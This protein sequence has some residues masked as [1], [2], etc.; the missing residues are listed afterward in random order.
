MKKL[1]PNALSFLRIALAFL[2]IP[3]ILKNDFVFACVLFGTAALSDFFDGYFAR[4]LHASSEFGAALDPLADKIL[5]TISYVLLANAKLIPL[6]AVAIVIGRDVLILLAVVACK[7]SNVALKMRPLMSSKINTA[8][9]ALFVSLVLTCNALSANVSCLVELFAA[10]VA[11]ST[12][13]SGAEYARKYYWIK[14]KL[15]K[16]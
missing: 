11:V 7:I 2:L 8:I 1:I 14:D 5:V 3:A 6:Y 13:F 10:V 9:Q 4:K 16:R 15:F 12:I